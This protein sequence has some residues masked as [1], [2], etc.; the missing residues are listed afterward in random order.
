MGLTTRKEAT[1][2]MIYKY[3]VS[4]AKNYLKENEIKELNKIMNS[5]PVW[6]KC[7]KNI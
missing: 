4:V 3:D 5:Y 1:D 7:I 6:I 2:G